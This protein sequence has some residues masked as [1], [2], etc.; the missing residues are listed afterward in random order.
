MLL[1]LLV[2][3]MTAFPPAALKLRKMEE[4]TLDPP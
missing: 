1:F 4:I 2:N 3:G